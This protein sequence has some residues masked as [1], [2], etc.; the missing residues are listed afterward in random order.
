MNPD[1]SVS[2]VRRNMGSPKQAGSAPGTGS[3]PVQNPQKPTPTYQSG[4]L[5]SQSG[6][7]KGHPTRGSTQAD[8]TAVSQ[9]SPGDTSGICRKPDLFVLLGAR[10]AK[11][12]LELGHLD[13]K[14]FDH[15]VAFFSNLKAEYRALRGW[16]RCWFSIWQLSHCEFSKVCT[17]FTIRAAAPW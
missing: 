1:P 14:K 7:L 16:F 4:T 11:L 17:Q 3:Q 6:T 15:D 13:T 10:K 9:Q 2:P 12:G 8:P 5:A